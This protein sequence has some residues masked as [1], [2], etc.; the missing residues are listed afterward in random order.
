M[1][2][3]IILVIAA[4]LVFPVTAHAKKC[5][6]VNQYSYDKAN[7][8]VEKA[9]EVM[10]SAHITSSKPLAG[11][12]LYTSDSDTGTTI[13]LDKGD[14]FKSRVKYAH[15]LIKFGLTPN[16]GNNDINRMFI[17][18]YRPGRDYKSMSFNVNV[19]KFVITHTQ[20]STDGTAKI[21]IFFDPALTF[22]YG[23]VNLSD[24]FKA[25]IDKNL[26]TIYDEVKVS[27]VAAGHIQVT[28][29][30]KAYM[31]FYNQSTKKPYKAGDL[32]NMNINIVFDAPNGF[33]ADSIAS[34]KETPFEPDHY[35][36]YKRITDKNAYAD[37]PAT[38]QAS[39]IILDADI[40]L[41]VLSSMVK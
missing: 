27:K 29:N 9:R 16:N 26:E 4:L 12:S 6:Y 2:H 23:F 30:L 13:K 39:N 5:A 3:K 41:P 14:I 35:K 11:L 17:K 8:L 32:Y 15:S 21:D 18:W 25:F 28:L 20:P 7:Y 40:T 33:F 1:K 38:S 10:V 36:C 22:S 34:S 31:D 19:D 37:V 24:I